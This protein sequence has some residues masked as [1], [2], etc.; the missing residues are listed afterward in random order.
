MSFFK[1][2]LFALLLC[3]PIISYACDGCGCSLGMSNP[4]LLSLYRSHYL[5]LGY[6]MNGFKSV[7]DHAENQSDYFYQVEWMSRFQLSEKWSMGLEVP[8]KYNLRNSNGINAKLSGLSDAKMKVNYLILRPVQGNNF[9]FSMEQSFGLRLPSGK[10][11]ES[12]HTKNLPDNFNLGFG[13]VGLFF[14]NNTAVTHG[15]KGLLLNTSFMYNLKNSNS[16]QFGNQAG[17]EMLAYNQFQTSKMNFTP[18]LGFS[19]DNY[20]IN[21]NA[22]GNKVPETG[23]RGL[24]GVFSLN[25]KFGN[26]LC[27]LGMATPISAQYSDNKVIAKNK[28]HV[29]FIY[30]INQ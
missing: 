2:K 18:A 1:I 7:A 12:I 6:S 3:T 20:W 10:Y 29:N 8:F 19:A 27:N 17:I 14:Q 16:Y 11:D 22:N 15:R 9:Q 24:Y 30:I 26:I 23:G 21:L 4:G 13:S 5:G 28:M 25:V